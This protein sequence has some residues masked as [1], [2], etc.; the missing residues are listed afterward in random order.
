[1]DT[2]SGPLF[3]PLWQQKT[4]DALNALDLV[5]L[6]D[7]QHVEDNTQVD[8][9][10]VDLSIDDDAEIGR[11][12]AS[13]PALCDRSMSGLTAGG[14]DSLSVQSFAQSSR[15]VPGR[16]PRRAPQKASKLPKETLCAEPP[17][18]GTCQR[19][20]RC[21]LLFPELLR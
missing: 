6:S 21:Q 5:C 1:M 19:A 10:E 3:M 16:L 9:S 4:A 7:V 20:G 2:K 17:L 12:D 15:V 18:T 8:F 13:L 14:G 11:G